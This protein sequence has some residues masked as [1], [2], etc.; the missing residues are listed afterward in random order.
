[1]KRHILLAGF[2]AALLFSA[3]HKKQGTVWDDH[4]TA[5][6]L[7]KTNRSLW[8]AD[9]DELQTPS[10]I[11]PITED[12]IALQEEDLKSHFAD[13]A[14]PQPKEVPGEDGSSIPGADRFFSASGEL[15]SLFRTLYFNTD[16][17]ILRGRDYLATIDL[18]ATYLKTHPK[19]YIFVEGHCDKRGPQ[20]YNL[21]LG[22]RRANYIRSLLIE[23]GA[24]LNQV[25]T[26]SYGK[27]K[28]AVKGDH[29]EALAKNRRVE[30][31]L[32]TGS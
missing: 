14:V 18:I 17:H 20:A 7:N 12:F 29:S 31:K 3:C 4:K 9:H 13:G 24:G 5:S 30:F 22:A 26:I 15:A 1:M 19:T 27:E 10:L 21:A 25:H 2:A 11:G 23:R 28:E 16:D 32:H 6:Q 8:G